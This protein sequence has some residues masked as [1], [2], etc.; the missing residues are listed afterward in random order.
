MNK[1]SSFNN[2]D[3]LLRFI[4]YL[5]LYETKRILHYNDQYT[6]NLHMV[7]KINNAYECVN[8]IKY[9]QNK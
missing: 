4:I 1:Y 7:Y 6:S 2:N 8:K 5:S 3:T 9:K